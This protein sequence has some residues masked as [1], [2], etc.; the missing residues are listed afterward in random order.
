LIPDGDVIKITKGVYNIVLDL[1]D[2]ENPKYE[3]SKT[4]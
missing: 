2:S 4:E 1:T 3:I